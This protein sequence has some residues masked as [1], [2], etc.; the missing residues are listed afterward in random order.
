MLCSPHTPMGGRPSVLRSAAA[1]AVFLFAF[2]LRADPP[3]NRA[4]HVAFSHAESSRPWDASMHLPQRKPAMRPLR[5]FTRQHG[6]PLVTQ[7][8][9]SELPPIPLTAIFTP[10]PSPFVSFAGIGYGSPQSFAPGADPPDP[11]GA[12]GPNHYVQIVNASFMIWDKAS[13]VLQS[14]RPINSLWAG[15]GGNPGNGC[16]TDNDGDPI[17]LYDQIADRWFISQFS[18]PNYGTTYTPNFQC[19]AISK[20]SDPT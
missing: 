7:A 3:V 15:Y 17:V 2:A 4:P 10:M 19:I 14:V 8:F 20:T 16:D 9:D 12:V 1:I 13:H 5:L 6:V 18:L 11:N